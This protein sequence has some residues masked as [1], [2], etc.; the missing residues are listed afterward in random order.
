MSFIP[1]GLERVRR[2]NTSRRPRTSFAD[3]SQDPSTAAYYPL[4]HIPEPR[5]RRHFLFE[6]S[7]GGW[8]INHRFFGPESRFTVQ[9]GT[10][11]EWT[12]ET[13]GGGWAHPIHIHFEEFQTI[14][15]NGAA[16]RSSPLVQ[17]G[18]K[19]TIRLDPGASATVRLQF[20][21]FLGRYPM[22]C[23][24]VVHE[25]H[26]MMTSWSIVPDPSTQARPAAST[27]TAKR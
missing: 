2:T 26:A 7:N 25:D 3:L 9:Q 22:H 11:E 12:L 6:S 10:A 13:G 8:Q 21:D 4:P 15:I 27:R 19:D 1:R 24:N 20:R 23:H 18:R 5:V 14:S 17:T 16:P